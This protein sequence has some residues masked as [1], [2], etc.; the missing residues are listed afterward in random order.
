M[1]RPMTIPSLL[2]AFVGLTSTG[3]PQANP[4]ATS[5]QQG[6]LQSMNT[7]ELGQ[8]LFGRRMVASLPNG[9]S[10]TNVITCRYST[11]GAGSA[12]QIYRLWYGQPPQWLDS[13][14]RG[15]SIRVMVRGSASTCPPTASEARSLVS[16]IYSSPAKEE[17]AEPVSAVESGNR[18]T[19]SESAA[20]KPRQSIAVQELTPHSLAVHGMNYEKEARAL[21]LGDFPHTNLDRASMEFDGLFGSYLNNFA[22]RCSEY[23][24]ANKV[25]M[26]KS[27]C[28]REQYPVNRYG[29]QVGVATCIEYR[30]V[31]TGL[32]AD[33]DLYDAQ[34]QVDRQAAKD[35]VRSTFSGLS[36]SNPLASAMHTMDAAASVGN[37]M[38]LLIQMNGCTN[39][40]LLRFQENMRRFAIGSPALRLAG[41][42]T[43]AQVT[44]QK[45]LAAPGREPNYGR[46]VE[47]LVAEHSKTWMMNRFVSGSVTGVRVAGQ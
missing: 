9:A 19:L 11:G 23:L 34:R 31:G 12:G 45:P 10:Q 26:T 30:D 5:P 2:I 6:A 17:A 22:K 7:E 39:P 33:P 32:Y 38:A 21:Y 35:M 24:P 1:K 18:R 29:A 36:G 42:E 44:P 46:L 13:V 25:E 14:P 28:A 41:A 8:S 20:T 4:A 40:S 27:E 37:D 3:L 43:L 16:R 47:D 15:H